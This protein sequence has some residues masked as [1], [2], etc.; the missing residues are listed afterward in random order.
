[1]KKLAGKYLNTDVTS[2][3]IYPTN[4]PGLGGYVP[5]D[6]RDFLV[7]PWLWASQL[8]PEGVTIDEAIETGMW[9]KH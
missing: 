6:S 7:E 8:L 1:M 2:S 9:P 4:N 3:A 5:T